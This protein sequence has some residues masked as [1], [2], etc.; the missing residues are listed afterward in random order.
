MPEQKATWSTLKKRLSALEDKELL[1]LIGELYKL[2]PMNRRFLE[3]RYSSSSKTLKEFKQIIDD[4]LYP[5]VMR[6]DDV[7][8]RTAKKAIST[9]SKATGDKPGIGELMVFY[10][11][12]ANQFT[13]DYGDMWEQFYISVESMFE[14][15]LKQLQEMQALGMEIEP[16]RKRLEKVVDSTNCIGWGYHD[17][18]TQ[19]YGEAFGE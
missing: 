8:F 16:L 4:A 12:R 5:N 10:V 6:N 18:L 19:L 13:L 17:M 3:T 15:A 14:R 9:Y 1:K 2:T 11:E 7:D